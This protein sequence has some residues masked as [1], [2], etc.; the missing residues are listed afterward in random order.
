[1]HLHELV[2]DVQS[3]PRTYNAG[4][5]A[6]PKKALNQLWKLTLWNTDPA[7]GNGDRNMVPFKSAVHHAGFFSGE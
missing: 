1:M 5:G 2:E 3:N 6:R 4:Q 7:I